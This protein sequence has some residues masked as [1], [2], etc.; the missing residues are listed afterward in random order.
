MAERVLETDFPLM[1]P[2][3]PPLSVHP[4]VVSDPGRN[5]SLKRAYSSEEVSEVS[6]LRPG[7]RECAAPRHSRESRDTS[8]TSDYLSDH[9]GPP[10]YTTLPQ[11]NSKHSSL[12]QPPFRPPMHRLE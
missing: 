3:N 7:P 11:H 4:R 8:D 2:P 1:A 6:P 9:A 12:S 10:G 5:G